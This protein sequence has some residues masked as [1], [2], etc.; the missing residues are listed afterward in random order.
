MPRGLPHSRQNRSGH[1]GMLSWKIFLAALTSSSRCSR[2]AQSIYYTASLGT[3]IAASSFNIQRPFG[4]MSILTVVHMPWCVPTTFNWCSCVRNQLA[5][6]APSCLYRQWFTRQSATRWYTMHAFLCGRL[7]GM[8]RSHCCP[9]GV[10]V[11]MGTCL[12]VSHSMLLTTIN[13]SAD[14]VCSHVQ[15]L[16]LTLLDVKQKRTPMVLTRR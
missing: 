7:F 1:Y 3:F 14:G 4:H 6:D 2:N 11:K 13:Y 12:C 15:A 9:Q 10:H 5:M 16:L 8:S